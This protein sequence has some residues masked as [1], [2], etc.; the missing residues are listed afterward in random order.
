MVTGALLVLFSGE[1]SLVAAEVE[2]ADGAVVVE[3]QEDSAVSVEAALV[4]E[5]QVVAGRR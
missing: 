2:V 4:E 5:A 3:A 1:V